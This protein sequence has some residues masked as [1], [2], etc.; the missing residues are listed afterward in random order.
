MRKGLAVGSVV[1]SIGPTTIGY[2]QKNIPLRFFQVGI[3]V[4]GITEFPIKGAKTF[5]PVQEKT[6][7]LLFLK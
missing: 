4:S 3:R 2:L 1:R 6:S 7:N 5:E